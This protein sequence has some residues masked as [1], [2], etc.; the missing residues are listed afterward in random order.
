MSSQQAAAGA[1]ELRQQFRKLGEAH[2]GLT[3]D[4]VTH[5]KKKLSRTVANI[6]ALQTF[7]HVGLICTR[8][9]DS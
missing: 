3:D 4:K 9:H 1:I 8:R 5:Q 6:A 7:L 2:C